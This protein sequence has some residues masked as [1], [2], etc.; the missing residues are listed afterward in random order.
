MTIGGPSNHNRMLNFME[1]LRWKFYNLKSV[2]S[3]TI[4]IPIF[5]LTYSSILCFYLR[6]RK[7]QEIQDLLT[8]FGFM[9]SDRVEKGTEIKILGEEDIL[10][11][12]IA[13]DDLLQKRKEETF[14]F[15][16]SVGMTWL[17]F[18]HVR[19]TNPGYITY[20]DSAKVTPIEDRRHFLSK[21]SFSVVKQDKTCSLKGLNREE[22]YLILQTL[23]RNE[24]I[25]ND[26][27]SESDEK[28]EFDA[29]VYNSID[30]HEEDIEFGLN[31]KRNFPLLEEMQNSNCLHHSQVLSIE[32]N[33]TTEEKMD[34]EMLLASVRNSETSVFSALERKTESLRSRIPL[35]YCKKCDMIVPLRTN[36]CKI[37][38]RCVSTF[39]HHCPFIGTCIGEYNHVRFYLLV[40]M[41]CILHHNTFPLLLKTRT[42]FN[43]LSPTDAIRNGKIHFLDVESYLAGNYP[44]I[45]FIPYF[46]RIYKLHDETNEFVCLKYLQTNFTFLVLSYILYGTCVFFMVLLFSHTLLILTNS[47]SYEQFKGTSLWYLK[48]R[49]EFFPFSK[50]IFLNI[51]EFFKRDYSQLVKGYLLLKVYFLNPLIQFVGFSRRGWFCLRKEQTYSRS[52]MEQ[53]KREIKDSWRRKPMPHVYRNLNYRQL[54][55]GQDKTIEDSLKLIMANP[56]RNKYYECC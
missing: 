12:E 10:R 45:A 47:T 43:Y 37:C 5:L 34:E 13:L 4:F 32:K 28:D 8:L 21:M 22:E 18:M 53:K 49:P 14:Y 50:G 39:D 2:H 11:L 16:V 15:F 41:V 31:I 42:P 54:K 1:N 33:P 40:S 17:M 24:T 19:L 55:D 48:D 51:V 36:H 52:K 6:D 26:E 46:D 38:N 27:E 30:L 35:N 23:T 25:E 3:P 56:C 20:K 9:E 29:K 7:I 44:W